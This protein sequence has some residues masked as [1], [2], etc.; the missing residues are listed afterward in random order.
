M[1]PA[2]F[3]PEQ[4][5]EAGKLLQ[6]A[7][8]AITGFALRKE[9]G[10]GNPNRLKQVWDEHVASHVVAEAE[11]VA[12]LPV[13]VAQE[14]SHV[15]ETL[16]ARLASMV[17]GINDRAVRASDRRAAEVVRAAGEQRDQADRELVDAAQT[18][19]D[20][21]QQLDSLQESH[22]LLVIELEKVRTAKQEQAVELAQVRERLTAVEKAAKEAAATASAQVKLLQ[23]QLEEQRRS[24]QKARER[25]AQAA[26]ALHQMEKQHLVDVEACQELR[27]EVRALSAALAETNAVSDGRAQDLMQAKAD[28]KAMREELK[29][30]HD[31]QANG[32]GREQAALAQ[33]KALQD[34]LSEAVKAPV[35]QPQK[36]AGKTSK[37]KAQSSG[38]ETKGD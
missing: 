31:A 18:V 6:S 32:L 13:E 22:D 25:E 38:N 10:G 11:P 20:L 17:V 28:V 1:R 19:D 24:E 29:A 35:K 37:A 4:I 23:G 5:I 30:A 33:I 2:D 16:V 12:E 27:T 3:K 34:A 7:G 9:V 15:S 26:G 14:L 8:R 21:E 36:A